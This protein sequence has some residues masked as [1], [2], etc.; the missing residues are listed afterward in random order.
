MHTFSIL[1]LQTCAWLVM[2][3][4]EDN[5]KTIHELRDLQRHFCV[6]SE[7]V[8]HD[9]E[10]FFLEIENK[11]E[12]TKFNYRKDNACLQKL[13]PNFR[14]TS[15]VELNHDGHDGTLLPY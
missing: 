15:L 9:C 3:S 5:I 4:D 10:K 8:L 13:K 14:I 2:A 7:I 6:R 11:I 12:K 1:E